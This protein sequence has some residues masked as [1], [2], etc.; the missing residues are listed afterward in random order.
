MTVTK[1]QLLSTGAALRH[2]EQKLGVNRADIAKVTIDG[3]DVKVSDAEN[4]LAAFEK[5]ID[6]AERAAIAAAEKKERESPNVFARIGNWGASV[7][8]SIGAWTRENVAKPSG[9]WIDENLP[10]L[11]AVANDAKGAINE[12]VLTAPEDLDRPATVRIELKS[13]KSVDIPVVV[14]DELMSQILRA[15]SAVSSSAGLVPFFGNIVQGG[16][17]VLALLASGATYLTGDKEMAR[18]FSGMARKHLVMGVVG[19]VPVAGAVTSVGAVHDLKRVGAGGLSVAEM[20]R[21]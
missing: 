11:N 20:V 7:G 16:T 13:G 14:R 8:E 15:T 18:A 6:D 3:A 9:A 4:E 1:G 5:A 12:N 17:G 10:A 2:A 19:F 21:V